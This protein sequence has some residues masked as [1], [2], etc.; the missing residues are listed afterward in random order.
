VTS[1]ADLADHDGDGKTPVA[2]KVSVEPLDTR[3]AAA[4][5]LKA[6]DSKD[7]EGI[8]DALRL[9]YAACD[10]ESDEDD[11]KGD[12]NEPPDDKPEE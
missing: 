1:L 3:A 7:V 9:F 5:L 11:E 2:V 10:A 4:K 12:D 6:V 8:E